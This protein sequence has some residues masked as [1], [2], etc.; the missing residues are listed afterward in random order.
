MASKSRLQIAQEKAEAAIK[1]TN[2]KIIYPPKHLDFCDFSLNF[3][4]F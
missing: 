2:Q 1:K 3:R 4:R